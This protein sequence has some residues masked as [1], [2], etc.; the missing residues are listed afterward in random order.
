MDGF[1]NI[2]KQKKRPTCIGRDEYVEIIRSHEGPLNIWGPPGVGKTFLIQ[3]CFE[4][5]IF[6]GDNENITEYI[7][8]IKIVFDLTNNYEVSNNCIIITHNP[9]D[10][11]DS[12][13]IEP[14]DVSD[15]VILGVKHRP[16]DSLEN[17][18]RFAKI[19]NGDIN[20]FLNIFEFENSIKDVFTKPREYIHDILCGSMKIK[21]DNFCVDDHGYS[22]GIVHENYIDSSHINLDNIASIMDSISIADILDT[23]MYEGDW[24]VYQYFCMFGIYIPCVYINKTLQFETMRPGS[25][26]TKYN[27]YKMRYKKLRELCSA[28][29]LHKDSIKLIHSKCVNEGMNVIET[30]KYYKIQPHQVDTINHV[31]LKS[32]IKPR[33]VSNLKKALA[34]D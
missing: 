2:T 3:H 21:A 31:A 25:S 18:E 27:N 9:I 7:K 29:F 12:L 24:S 4:H 19:S 13:E 6:L 32:K 17:I 34:N 16:D 8:N 23:R 20:Y 33:V 5:A 10:E 22:M 26:W 14:L 28:T 15:L 11:I 1:I 30:L